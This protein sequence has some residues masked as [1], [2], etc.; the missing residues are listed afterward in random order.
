MGMVTV[1]QPKGSLCWNHS[2][3]RLWWWI[4]EPLQ[5]IKLCGTW[6]TYT[7]SHQ[8]AFSACYIILEFCGT[9][10]WRDTGQCVQGISLYYFLQLFVSLQVSLYKFQLKKKKEKPV[11]LEA[12][13]IINFIKLQSLD[14]CI[15]S[16]LLWQK[17]KCT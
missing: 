13:K 15:F 7:Q 8:C 14:T 2:V 16:I 17:E 3:S 5:G 11:S 12:M 9:L 6:H 4:H 1:G 10:P